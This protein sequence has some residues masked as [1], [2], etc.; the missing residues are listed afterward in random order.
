MHFPLA[1]AVFPSGSQ[2]E[3]PS[4]GRPISS[5]AVSS[6]NAHV[7]NDASA[8]A[9]DVR[10]RV[11][12]YLPSFVMTAPSS[13]DVCSAS[14]VDTSGIVQLVRS[15][16]GSHVMSMPQHFSGLEPQGE[17][18]PSSCSY[19]SAAAC[20]AS[21][22]ETWTNGELDYFGAC[23]TDSGIASNTSLSVGSDHSENDRASSEMT[24]ADSAGVIKQSPATSTDNPVTSPGIEFMGQQAFES[25]VS[26][27]TSNVGLVTECASSPSG[28]HS[29]TDSIAL[30]YN[31]QSSDGI[32]T[33]SKSDSRTSDSVRLE[34]RQRFIRKS[35]QTPSVVNECQP[36][37]TCPS[38]PRRLSE[39]VKRAMRGGGELPNPPVVSSACDVG[40]TKVVIRITKTRCNGGGEAKRS[41]YKEQWCVQPILTPIAQTADNAPAVQGASPSSGATSDGDSQ[42]AKLVNTMSS[43]RT[44]SCEPVT[45]ASLAQTN[46][47]QIGRC[48]E[49]AVP[50]TD[51][52]NGA[53]VSAYQLP[54]MFIVE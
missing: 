20:T 23:G 49:L 14:S 38:L 11:S 17:R 48:S 5:S 44:A 19:S 3:M 53:S 41:K 43:G 15:S 2:S 4:V 34:A 13:S 1:G 40:P 6:Y 54:G 35:R 32:L 10:T 29:R 7:R 39:S 26:S 31:R 33:G 9:V 50:N 16:C 27:S 36:A 12:S 28:N 42:N 30:S 52:T 37:I 18:I 51:A 45:A 25:A 8:S 21:P 24:P 22:H 46:C 47:A